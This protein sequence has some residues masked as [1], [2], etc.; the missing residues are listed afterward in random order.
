MKNFRYG[1][2]ACVLLLFCNSASI[3]QQKKQVNHQAQSWF[4]VN[5]TIRLSN[6]CGLLAD[7]HVR[8]NNFL[9]DPSFYF[10]RGAV[11][12]WYNDNLS[13]AAGYGHMWVAPTVAGYSTYSN[14]HRIFQQ[15]QLT[16]KLGK[17]NLLQK[18]RNEQRWQEIIVSDVSTHSNKF[19]DRLRYLINVGIPFSKN[20]RAP[21]FVLADE[22]CVNFG[23]D[24]VY[25][26]FD[27][28]RL[29]FGVK[30][31]INKQWS[32]DIGYMQVFQQKS[33]GFI[34]DDNDTFRWFFYYTPDL[35]KQ[36]TH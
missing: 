21:V 8:R 36:K 13:F 9:A 1:V 32:F 7:A 28:N 34:Y 17:V 29:F 10:L 6:K 20:K 2:A 5:S 19:T 30:Q 14:E 3:A 11:N 23:T 35:R 18:V 12:Y 15:V 4:S 31:T 27:Q 26:S 24:V 33:S 22:L 25:N 16:S